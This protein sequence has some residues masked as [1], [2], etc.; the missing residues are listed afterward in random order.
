MSET[1]TWAGSISGAGASTAI[2]EITRDG[3]RIEGQLRL[4][5]PAVG[6]MHAC[7]SG[8]W[9]KDDK[10]SAKL[11]QFKGNF[12]SEM[13]LPQSGSLECV[14]D[15]KENALRGRWKTDAGEGD[16]W[17]ICVANHLPMQAVARVP[18]AIPAREPSQ[19]AITEAARLLRKPIHN[20]PK[21]RKTRWLAIV[22][23]VVLA[24]L[25]GYVLMDLVMDVL[26]QG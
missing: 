1:T 19:P 13:A 26:Q 4:F 22:V 18:E 6:Q 8:E 10:I 15:P 2:V 12:S 20:D 14:F 5:E 25:V 24:A 7:L 17:W 21:K 23:G 11:E 16:L 9:D 3:T